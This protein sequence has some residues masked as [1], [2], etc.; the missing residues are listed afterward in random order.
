MISPKGL[1]YPR[2]KKFSIIF[3]KLTIKFSNYE[4]NL[5]VVYLLYSSLKDSLVSL[6][7]KLTLVDRLVYILIKKLEDQNI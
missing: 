2:E 4:S 7:N 3:S 5:Y 6:L 1:S